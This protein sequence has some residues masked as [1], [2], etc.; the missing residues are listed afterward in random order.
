M[1]YLNIILDTIGYSG[2]LVHLILKITHTTDNPFLL[3]ISLVFI[4]LGSSVQSIRT[5]KK[6]KGLELE[7]AHKQFELDNCLSMSSKNKLVS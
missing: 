5:R 7:I 2:F 4:F 6:I 1:K 3:Y